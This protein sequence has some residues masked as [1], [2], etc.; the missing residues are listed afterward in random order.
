[1]FGDADRMDQKEIRKVEKDLVALCKKHNVTI[2]AGY[3]L[4]SAMSIKRDNVTR[5]FLYEISP[6]GV[7][8]SL[9]DKNYRTRGI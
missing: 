8:Y 3:G 2:Q 7:K 9:Y 6:R 1:M 4:G 5:T